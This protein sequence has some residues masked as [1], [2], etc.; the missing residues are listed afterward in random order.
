[1]KNENKLFAGILVLCIVVYIIV[2]IKKAITAHPVISALIGLPILVGLGILAYYSFKREDLK[3]SE[4]GFLSSLW[5]KIMG[6]T[7]ALTSEERETK[8]RKPIPDTLKN[9][10][11]DNAGDK[12]QM[13]GKKGN[14]KIHH[15]DANPGNNNITNLILLCG[16]CHDDAHHGVTPKVRLKNAREKQKSAG[17]V[18]VSKPKE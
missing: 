6:L 9:K 10:V 11:Y 13:C 2:L 14:L 16:N 15:I 7:K 5:Q 1:M 4:K 3:E 18:S 17:Y 12:C 8:E